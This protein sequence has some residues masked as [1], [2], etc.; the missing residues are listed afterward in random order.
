MSISLR[1]PSWALVSFAILTLVACGGG[2]GIIAVPND[3]VKP[4]FTLTLSPDSLQAVVPASGTTSTI[5]T[6]VQVVPSG[7]FS[8]VVTFSLQG[9]PTGVTGAFTPPASATTSNLQLTITSTAIPSSTP[10]TVTGTAAGVQPASANLALKTGALEGMPILVVVE[11]EYTKI[12]AENITPLDQIKKIAAFMAARPEYAQTGVYE[13]SLAAWGV[14]Q[15][16]WRHIVSNNPAPGHRLLPSAALPAASATQQGATLADPGRV[17]SLP[18]QPAVLPAAAGGNNALPGASTARFLNAFDPDAVDMGA[19][20]DMS[21]WLTTAGWTVRP[22]SNASVESLKTVA[23]DGFLYFQGHGGHGVWATDSDHSWF[24][25]QSST[26]V[27]K[28]LSETT[29]KDDLDTTRLVF[30]TDKT[31]SYKKD[32]FGKEVALTATW[33][34]ITYAFA[35]KYWGNFGSNAIVFINAC[36]SGRDTPSTNAFK[37]IC[38]SKGANV[39][40]GWSDVAAAESAMRAARYFVDRC[41]G[42]NKFEAEY[43]AQRPF[44]WDA[45][46]NDMKS[47]GIAT[48]GNGE[49]LLAYV[50]VPGKPPAILAPSI[51]QM[52]V[53]EFSGVLTLYGYFG[54]DQGKVSVGNTAVAVKNWAKE[55]ITCDIP[56]TASGDVVVEVRSLKSNPRPLS[57]WNIPLN[58]SWSGYASADPVVMFS[59]TPSL[60]YRL[61]VSGYREKPGEAPKFPVL[62]TW[63]IPKSTLTIRGSGT[64]PMAKCTATLSGSF[65]VP[66]LPASSDGAANPT[67][68]LQAPLLVD[69]NAKTGSLGL[70]LATTIS[71]NAMPWRLTVTG[72]DCSG[73]GGAFPTFGS[74]KGVF[75]FPQKPDED[76]PAEIPLPGMGLTFGSGFALNA[77]S[78]TDPRVTGAIKVQW[79]LTAPSSPP[80]PADAG[81]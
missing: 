71:I 72:A 61:D 58:Y 68:S 18:S 28:K 2:V 8:N 55:K 3:S 15:N 7:G 73:S 46:L 9:A 77:D 22:G 53:E 65:A 60:R 42:A 12:L 57:E 33:Y 76:A 4:A 48:G 17:S 14:L 35:E 5:Q 38:T 59:S 32:I 24:S 66:T 16:G 36:H 34:G 6:G 79:S 19:I 74:L 23:G 52:I 62:G 26:L 27:D 30:I 67:I 54:G 50:G 44:P 40:F 78:Y 11:D 1:L 37:A 75:M 49:Q 29:Y 47:K 20:A 39:H 69:T 21:A 25:L 80:R 81:I 45:V 64:G 51:Q 10:M 13:E 31:G 70:A 41:V 63:P 43:P 56:L